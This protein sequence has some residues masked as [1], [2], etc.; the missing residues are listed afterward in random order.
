[1]DARFALIQAHDDSI[2]RYQRLLN[3]Q[4]TDLEREYIESRISEKRLTLQSIHEARGR[5]NALPANR[6]V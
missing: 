3:T 6:G 2:R 4:L 1:M 5:L